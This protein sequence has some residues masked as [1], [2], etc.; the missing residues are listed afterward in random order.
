MNKAGF[1]PLFY[2][3]L[4][5]GLIACQPA[6]PMVETLQ[7]GDT[8]DGMNLTTGAGD[9][10]PLWTFCSQAQY[11][12]NT[13][14]SDCSVPVVPRLAIGH[15]L[16]PD[17]DTL[18]RLDWSQISWELTLDGQPV[19]LESFGTYD[20]VMPAMSHDPSPVREVFVQFTAWDVVLT[21]LSPGEH[22]IHGV[23]RM[24][25]DSYAWMKRLTIQTSD[26]FT[27]SSVP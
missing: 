15:I 11:A 27:T 4:V 7:P 5:L 26:G 20:F 23:A 12:G 6:G 22:K 25:T 21:N 10:A 18:T 16:L 13:T 19:D 17:D 1:S 8:L 9:A 24:G 3:G 2:F 14:V